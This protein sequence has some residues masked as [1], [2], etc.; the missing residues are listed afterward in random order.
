MS[1]AFIQIN[2]VNIIITIQNNKE[3]AVSPKQ[4]FYAATEVTKNDVL[5]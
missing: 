1:P 4:L 5:L 2:T 3:R